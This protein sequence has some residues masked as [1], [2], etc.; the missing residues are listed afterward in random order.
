MIR[1]P[2]GALL[3]ARNEQ[4]LGIPDRQGPKH[5]RIQDSEDRAVDADAEGQRK[6]D[7]D[8]KPGLL[9]NVRIAYRMSW[10]IVSTNGS[11]R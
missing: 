1:G 5:Q 6:D 9:R 11:P 10:A 4:F 8:T 2:G 3:A 7:R